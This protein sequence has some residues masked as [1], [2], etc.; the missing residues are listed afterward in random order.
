MDNRYIIGQVLIHIGEKL[1]D[2]T[3]KLYN[4]FVLSNEQLATCLNLLKV[5]SSPQTHVLY[6]GDLA[7]RYGVSDRTIR[8]WI[9]DGVIPHGKKHDSGDNRDYWMSHELSSVDESLVR[10]GYLKRS[11]L[12]SAD[13]RLRRLLENYKW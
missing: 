6:I 7:M 13:D 8:N 12:Q 2:P 4:S 9:H 10:K 11:Q 3:S 1:C 5:A